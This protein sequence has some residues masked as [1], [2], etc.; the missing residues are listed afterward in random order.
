MKTAIIGAK[1]Q[2]GSDLR[3]VIS[4]KIE[5]WDHDQVDVCDLDSL[6]KACEKFRPN[7]IINT[8]AFHDVD[9]CEIDRGLA[10]RVNTEGA[11]NVA[12]VAKKFD[13]VVVYI[14]TDYVFGLDDK[15]DIH[16]PYVEEDLPGPCNF[17]GLTKNWGE[18][19]V[20]SVTPNHY[21]IRTCGLYGDTHRKNFVET[22]FKLANN[23]DSRP[24]HVVADQF[25][26]PTATL[27]LAQY[28]SELIYTG[29]YGTYHITN[30]GGTNWFEFAA[31]LFALCKMDVD[32]RPCTSEF[33]K[34][35]AT[36]PKMS[37]LNNSKVQNLPIIA[38]MRPCE[39]ALAFYLKHKHQ[40][41]F[42][43]EVF[44]DLFGEGNHENHQEL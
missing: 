15:R 11:F 33:F 29:L 1:G 7:I 18:Q 6:E 16:S 19:A 31:L 39:I 12:L 24:I 41:R 22:M 26:S 3:G 34:R 2:L 20:R 37:V 5:S 32:M 8:A 23:P 13:A 25:C 17:Y 4:S 10:Y 36:R 43:N 40:D 30:T 27:D 9:K 44:M 28:L 38:E 35:E 14:S 21:I 42:N